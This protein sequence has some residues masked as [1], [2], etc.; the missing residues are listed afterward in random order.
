MIEGSKEVLIKLVGLTPDE[1]AALHRSLE[2]QPGVT[3]SSRQFST[4]GPSNSNDKRREF[5]TI[6][7]SRYSQE[8]GSY[9]VV[10]RVHAAFACCP[11][12]R[13]DQRG[14]LLAPRAVLDAIFSSVH[15]L[16]PPEERFEVKQKS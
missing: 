16:F 13:F 9:S 15:G 1:V 10:L 6:A 12:G 11:V 7:S 4:G 3:V 2:F 14:F 5:V 8:S